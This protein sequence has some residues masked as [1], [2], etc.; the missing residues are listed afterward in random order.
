MNDALDDPTV[1]ILRREALAQ[2]YDDRAIRDLVKTGE[3]HR[4]RRGAYTSKHLWDDA[5]PVVRHRLRARAVLRAAHPS[6]LL[7]HASAV[8]ELGGAL[9]GVDLSEVHV[10]RSD[11]K[12][13]RREAGVVHHCGQIDES[14]VSVMHGVRVSSVARSVVE[15]STMADLESCLV[16]ANWFLGK[17]LTTKDLLESQAERARFWP[18][19]L[20][21]NLLVRLVDGRNMWPGEAR[22]SYLLWHERLPRA[23]PQ[24]S[25]LDG[26]G[27]LLGIVDFAWPE[28]GVFLEFDGRI[29][30]ERL[31]RDGE[32]LEEVILREKRREEQI[33][34]QT[35]WVCIRVTWDDLA[36]PATTAHRIRRLLASRRP[37]AG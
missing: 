21:N 12:S 26:G 28:L 3:W 16:T 2:G 7:T 4:I 9:W 5:D 24:Y 14:E 10:T 17:R 20:R 30:Y 37:V 23:V 8:A 31:R 25:V 29:K 35:G 32:P 22:T 27:N 33:C 19:S 15:L 11:G 13:G 36:R 6:A 18:G 34:A 1:V